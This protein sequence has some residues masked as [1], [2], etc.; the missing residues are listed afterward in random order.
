[1]LCFVRV[2]M[3]KQIILAHMAV[4]NNIPECLSDLI[5]VKDKSTTIRTRAS[6]DP[7]LVRVPPI[8][9]TCGNSFIERSF[10]YAAFTL[11]NTNDLDIR[12]LHVWILSKNNQDASFFI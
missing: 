11:F 7:C 10:K 6:F 2:A 9:K 4:H 12:L 8:S 1:M 5:N 3:L